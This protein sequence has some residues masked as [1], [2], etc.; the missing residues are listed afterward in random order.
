MLAKLEELLAAAEAA[1]KKANDA[2]ELS[3]VEIKFL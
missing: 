3:A 2:V 1:I